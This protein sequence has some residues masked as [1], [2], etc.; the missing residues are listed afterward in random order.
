MI[1]LIGLDGEFDVRGEEKE[2]LSLVPSG[3]QLEEL[4]EEELC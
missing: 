3:L 1:E 2:K 4:D